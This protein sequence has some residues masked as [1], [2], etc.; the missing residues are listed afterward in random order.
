MDPVLYEQHFR[1]EDRHW[2]F[3]GRR[4]LV[5]QELARRGGASAGTILDLG[6][7]TGGMLPHLRRFGSALGLDSAE[8]AAQGCL[9]REVPTRQLC[10]PCSRTR[11]DRPGK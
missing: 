7:G 2:W 6:C 9:R 4:E 8:E 11:S 3:A 5:L 10:Q 1:L